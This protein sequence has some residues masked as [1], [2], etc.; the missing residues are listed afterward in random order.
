MVFSLNEILEVAVRDG[1][2]R[3][4][5]APETI[6]EPP[7]DV[8]EVRHPAGTGGFSALSL[9]APVVGPQLGGGVAA[10]GAG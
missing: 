7:R 8:L 6:L 3:G 5:D 2:R 10:L 4:R 1:K 9:Q